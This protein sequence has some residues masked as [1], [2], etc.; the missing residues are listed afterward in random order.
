M[1]SQ[2]LQLKLWIKIQ[3]IIS[4]KVL[5]TS[6]GF[7]FHEAT[8]LNNF[9]RTPLVISFYSFSKA[10]FQNVSCQTG[11][12]AFL[13]AFLVLFTK[14]GQIVAYKSLLFKI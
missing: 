5:L 8:N 6:H 13:L 2:L 7:T 11:G 10:F 3:S 4:F 9:L 14:E 12:E 1:I